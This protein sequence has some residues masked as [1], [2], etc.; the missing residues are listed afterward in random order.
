MKSPA[1]K[2]AGAEV[3]KIFLKLPVYA[4]ANY[5]QLSRRDRYIW[6]VSWFETETT[7]GGI[8]QFFY[9]DSGNHTDETLEALDAIGARQS[10]QFIRAALKLLPNQ[11]VSAD[12]DARRR[13]IAAFLDERKLDDLV[14]GRVDSNLYQLLLDYWS[15]TDPR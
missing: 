8:D 14:S 3:H 1:E 13:E 10:A 6:D 2:A 7:N 5:H 4:E 12:Q 11:R 9:N 15:K